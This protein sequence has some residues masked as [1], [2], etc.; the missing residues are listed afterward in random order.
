MNKVH[1]SLRL[2]YEDPFSK[3]FGILYQRRI[4]TVFHILFRLS[5]WSAI[6]WLVWNHALS[7]FFNADRI[8]PWQALGVS[9]L[10]CVLSMVFEDSDSPWHEDATSEPYR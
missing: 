1:Q 7:D 4:R 10:L 3:Q 9:V 8:S 2:R 6:V 5:C